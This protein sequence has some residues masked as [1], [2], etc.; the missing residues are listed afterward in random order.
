LLYIDSDKYEKYNKI[1][2]KL[3]KLLISQNYKRNSIK[4]K[5]IDTLD[6]IIIYFVVY[7]EEKSLRKILKP[8]IIKK[9]VELDSLYKKNLIKITKHKK[10]SSIKDKNNKNEYDFAENKKTVNKN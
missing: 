4:T 10:L 7:K 8:I 3:A 9:A 5:L 2:E 6:S 1:F